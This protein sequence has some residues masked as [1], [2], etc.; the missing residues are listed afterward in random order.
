MPKGHG[1]LFTN[2]KTL[3]QSQ[4]WSDRTLGYYYKHI[5]FAKDTS[6]TKKKGKKA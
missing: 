5:L 4:V 1:K 3:I 6:S 2:S